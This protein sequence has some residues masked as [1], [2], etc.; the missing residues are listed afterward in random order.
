MSWEVGDG[1]LVEPCPGVDIDGIDDLFHGLTG[2]GSRYQ[3][4]L[5][6]AGRSEEQATVRGKSQST[7]E[8]GERL[9][10]VDT[11]VSDAGT[12]TV[13]GLGRGLV[14]HRLDGRKRE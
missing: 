2:F 5:V 14:S 3:R 12:T 8:G 4:G 1:W 6:Q 10:G 7:E 13:M 9:V 11:R